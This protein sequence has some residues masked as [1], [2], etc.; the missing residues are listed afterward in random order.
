MKKRLSV[1]FDT[2]DPSS[3]LLYCII[4]QVKSSK[5]MEVLADNIL[6]MLEDYKLLSRYGDDPAALARMLMAFSEY[7]RASGKPLMEG[8]SS[9]ASKQMS[10]GSLS[11]GINNGNASGYKD[12]EGAKVHATELYDEGPMADAGLEKKTD[13]ESEID[14]VMSTF[15]ETPRDNTIQVKMLDA[16]EYEAM[17][18]EIAKE[19]IFSRLSPVEQ[20]QLQMQWAYM[21]EDE[22]YSEI[23]EEQLWFENQ[24]E[25]LPE[26]FKSMIEYTEHEMNIRG[27]KRKVK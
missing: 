4:K 25:N 16:A 7:Y 17:A 13:G 27:Y 18:V 3:M 11:C 1:F 9:L 14:G 19:Y 26:G 15:S 20:K 5:R 2:E 8:A 10:Y 12:L 22:L 23:V 6:S 21:D 24:P